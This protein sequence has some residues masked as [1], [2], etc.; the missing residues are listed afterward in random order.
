MSIIIK[1]TAKP[2]LLVTWICF[3][4]V[5]Q[6]SGLATSGEVTRVNTTHRRLDGRRCKCAG[7]QQTTNQC[8]TLKWLAKM[9]SWQPVLRV[10]NNLL[11]MINSLTWLESTI[12]IS[13]KCF[14]G[15]G[16]LSD[17]HGAWNRNW[18]VTLESSGCL[19]NS[20]SR[21]K[22]NARSGVERSA[23]WQLLNTRA[24]AGSNMVFCMEETASLNGLV[25][26]G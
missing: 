6:V 19:L 1:P 13:P 24:R 9:N 5:L 16:A 23:F 20:S 15:I 21:L 3:Q 26:H 10:Y 25:A 8:M 14:A 7:S 2:L 22:Y 18:N 17:P 11:P 4:W 12:V